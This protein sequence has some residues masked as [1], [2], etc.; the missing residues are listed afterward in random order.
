MIGSLFIGMG[1]GLSV[2][3]IVGYLKVFSPKAIGYFNCG[4]GFAGIF[5]VI[6][7]FCFQRI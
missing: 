2:L 1:A 3:T 7:L 5:S 4:A 6:I